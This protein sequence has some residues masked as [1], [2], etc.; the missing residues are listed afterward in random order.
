MTLELTRDSLDQAGS[1]LS[2]QL[3]QFMPRL[4]RKKYANLWMEQGTYVPA[5]GD[6]EAGAREVIETTISERGEAA[7]TVDG[8]DDIPMVDVAA[9]E[10]PFPA[11]IISVGC[12]YN[13][14]GLDADRKAGKNINAIRLETM[15]LAIRERAHKIGCF[16]SAKHNVNGLFNCPR[17]PIVNS[18][19]DADGSGVTAQDHLNFIGDQLVKV[20]SD[21]N[22]T[23]GIDTIAVPAKLHN[24]WTRTRVPNTDKNVIRQI[25]EDFGP[26]AGGTLRRIVKMNECRSDILEANGVMNSGTNKDRLVFMPFDPNAGERKYFA[27]RRMAPQLVGMNYK[28]FGYMGTTGFIDHY[29]QGFLLVDIPKL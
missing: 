29:P 12:Q 16:G 11:V 21:S 19:Y 24:V 23:E 14:L 6:L 10:T 2:R 18:N 4:Y 22:L 26:D 1:Y 13:V 20:E 27:M 5:V 28:V 25:L 9:A 17:I 7:V 8:P 3:Q 15:N